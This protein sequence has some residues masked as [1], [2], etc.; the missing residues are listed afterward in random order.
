MMNKHKVPDTRGYLMSR[1]RLEGKLHNTG[2]LEQLLELYPMLHCV[3]YG[4]ELRYFI[5]EPDISSRFYIAE[6]CDKGIAI[7]IYSKSTPLMFLRE[8]MLRMLSLASFVGTVYEFDIKSIF[9]YLIDILAKDKLEYYFK[10]TMHSESRGSE[11]VLSRR[12]LN[13]LKENYTLKNNVASTEK[14]TTNLILMLLRLKY[15]GICN[16]RTAAPE[17][18][19]EVDSLITII[20]NAGDSGAM[21]TWHS[22]E[23]FSISW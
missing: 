14:T 19:I 17:L 6:F 22:K 11:I 23:T 10:P 1:L 3:G 16:V 5:D 13:L 9:P 18:G 20:K 15:S 2:R 21:V 8:G 12:I 7:E 4:N